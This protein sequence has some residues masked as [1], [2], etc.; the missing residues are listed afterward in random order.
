MKRVSSSA[1][2]AV[3][4]TAVHLAAMGVTVEPAQAQ[5]QQQQ[6]PVTAFVNVNVVPMDEERVL[7]NYTVVVEQGRVTDMGP[8]GSV[9]VPANAQRIDAG[10]KYLMP[11]LAEMHGHTPSGAFAETV[12]FL[13]VANGVTTVRG[14]LGLDGHLELKRR[15][16]S[17]QLI[18]PSLYLA[19]PSFNGG[20]VTSPQHAVEKVRR[21]KAE[22]WDH[23]KIHP[24][25]TVEQYDALAR[26]ASAVGMRFGGHVPAEVGIVHAI[27][28]GQ[29]TF[30]HL[31]G[32]LEYAGGIDSPLDEAKLDHAIEL[33][34]Q[35]RAA[36]VP[37][38]VLWEVGIIGV[39]DVDAME[40]YPEMQYWPQRQ[41]RSW[42]TRVRQQQQNSNADQAR[43]FAENR[44]ILLEKLNDAGV[45]VL[46]GTDSPQ[47][48]SVPGFSLH[49][50]MEAMAEAGMTPYE[51]LESG[52][53]N[54]GDYFR[55]QDNFGTVGVG[56]RADFILTNS[57]PLEDVANVADRVGVM[58][59]G[60][61]LSEEAIQERLAEIAQQMSS[62]TD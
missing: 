3:I 50:E 6:P 8:A 32:Y 53:K 44:R 22:G 10:G 25:L 60:R 21:Q 24:G 1:L 4:A 14:M 30:D 57:N 54:V 18:G 17:G 13:Y 55:S 39:G 52:T 59:R 9:T 48:F 26:T 20:S 7:R 37:T 23:L 62:T 11:G 56:Q 29:D 47:I 45:T 42:A 31:D 2:V 12:M 35:A 58:V 46:M 19:G 40:N 5:G 61:W 28:M 41:V 36:V 38:Q 33:T 51:I 15:T 27:K 49:R 43:A 34:K 16:N